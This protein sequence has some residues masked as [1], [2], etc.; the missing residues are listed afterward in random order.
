MIN[1]K[2]M[3]NIYEYGEY[4]IGQW[5]NNNRHGKGIIYYKNGNIK[6][7]GDFVNGEYQNNCTIY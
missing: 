1:M 4:Y 5:L 7:E 6:Y 3:E 2:E